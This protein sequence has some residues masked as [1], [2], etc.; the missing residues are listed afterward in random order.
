VLRRLKRVGLQIVGRVFPPAL[1]GHLSSLFFLAVILP[2]LLSGIYYFVVA[3]D[4]YVVETDFIVRRVNG[5]QTGGLSAVFR[6]FGIT[7]AEDESHAVIDFVLSRDAARA[8]NQEHPLRRMFANPA[9]DWFA[10]YP[11]WWELWRKENFESLYEFYKSKVEAW[12]ESRGGII[13]LKV[14]AFSPEDAKTFSLLLLRQSEQLINRTNQRSNDDTVK[15]AE[16]EVKRAQAKVIES[17]EAV[18]SFR[19]AELTLDPLADSV[20]TLDL[21]GRMAAELADT[22]RQLSETLQGSP[23]NPTVQGLRARI[24]ALTQQIA[25]EKTKV[26]GQDTSLAAK[27]TTF[28]RLTLQRQF[29]DKGLAA[30][31]DSLQAAQQNARRQQLYIET[32]VSP[33]LPDEAR[34]PRGARNVSAVFVVC[35]V[36]FSLLWLIV[37]A[38]KEHA[39]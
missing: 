12:Y 27:V 1:L 8:V 34:E 36:A 21:I 16:N 39:H 13:K 23:S 28:E 19:N 26:V 2:T 3:S 9:A 22:Q 6:T 7:R 31:F 33:N 18:T 32:I 38:T 24:T 17:Q 15:F 37:S 29:A 10:K 14:T 5:N 11:R 20:K 25:A 4:R 30:A 35:F